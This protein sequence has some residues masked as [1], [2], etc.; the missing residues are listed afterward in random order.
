MNDIMH[1]HLVA[2]LHSGHEVTFDKTDDGDFG[3]A[4]V[5]EADGE[6]WYAVDS[7]MDRALWAASP[8]HGDNEPMPGPDVTTGQGA[9]ERD[10]EELWTRVE[11]IEAHRRDLSLLVRMLADEFIVDHPGGL[12][13]KRGDKPGPDD[14]ARFAA[15]EK[16]LDELTPRGGIDSEKWNCARCGAECIGGRPHDDLCHQC[17]PAPRCPRCGLYPIDHRGGECIDPGGE[18]EKEARLSAG[19]EVMPPA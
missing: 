18:P 7:A 14:D 8:L 6:S 1:D 16:R 10:V 15:I 19:D 11:A 17:E 9:L 13:A 4:V 2:L 3:V 12:T 5:R